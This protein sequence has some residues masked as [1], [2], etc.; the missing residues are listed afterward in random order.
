MIYSKYLKYLHT[1]N[2]IVNYL[3]Q[4]IQEWNINE[5]VFTITTDNGSNVVKARKIFKDHNNIT[6]ISCAAH[7]LQLVIGKGLLPAEKLVTRAKYLISYFTTS[8][9]TE[10][11]IEI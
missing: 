6:R 3:I 11:L 8:K 4:I 10:R 2:I 9:Q 7:T 1:S 5:K